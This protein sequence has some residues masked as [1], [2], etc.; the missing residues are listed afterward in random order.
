NSGVQEFT[1]PQKLHE[2]LFSGKH[3]LNLKAIIDRKISCDI[4]SYSS[5]P[6]SDM[7][8]NMC[9]HTGERNH[10]CT[11]GE[12]TESFISS[13]LLKNHQRIVLKWKPFHCSICGAKFAEYMLLDSHRRDHFKTANQPTLSMKKP[14]LESA[15]LYSLEK[16]ELSGTIFMEED[17]I[18]SRNALR[19]LKFTDP[20]LNA[21]GKI[22]SEAVVQNIIS[23]LNGSSQSVSMMKD[24]ECSEC[25]FRTRC[26]NSW[27]AH[28]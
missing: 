8:V 13:A 19:P 20:L 4:C 9:I 5:V 24:M 6:S 7:A 28:L 22:P 18:S 25:D 23:S 16:E 11:I 2:Q 15:S 27:M 21:V 1:P 14:T 10:N 26:A 17:E 12:C 3:M